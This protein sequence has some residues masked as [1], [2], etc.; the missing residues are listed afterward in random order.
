MA[1]TN[2][3][4]NAVENKSVLVVNSVSIENDAIIIRFTSDGDERKKTMP[5]TEKGLEIKE[6]LADIFA[7]ENF[8]P[9]TI[10]NLVKDWG[11]LADCCTDLAK[12]AK[13]KQAKIDDM[14]TKLGL[15]NPIDAL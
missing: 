8:D 3:L 6:W 11:R 15:G 2:E 14:F 12:K 10:W 9:N 13:E 5:L 1:K 4:L 7:N